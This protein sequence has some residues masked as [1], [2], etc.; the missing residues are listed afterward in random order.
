MN[1]SFYVDV[2]PMFTL[3][4][5][6]ILFVWLMILSSVST[7]TF[8]MDGNQGR[9]P[10]EYLKMPNGQLVPVYDYNPKP[11][12]TMLMVP[13][14]HGTTPPHNLPQIV[15]PQMMTRTTSTTF[16]PTMN[17][18]SFIQMTAPQQQ[19][20]PPV[21]TPPSLAPPSPPT[22][23]IPVGASAI[24]LAR[25]AAERQKRKNNDDDNPRSSKRVRNDERD[26][27]DDEDDE[28]DY[29]SNDYKGESSE[30]TEIAFAHDDTEEK[31][32]NFLFIESRNYPKMMALEDDDSAFSYGYE[33]HQRGEFASARAHFEKD[34]SDA[35]S[36]YMLAHYHEK[37]ISYRSKNLEVARRYYL[38]AAEHNCA[39]A[40]F[41]VGY[42]F[43]E[44]LCNFPKKLNKAIHWYERAA[45]H[46]A[47][48]RSKAL[49][50]LGSIYENEDSVKDLQRALKIY[51]QAANG[52]SKGAMYRL[53]LFYLEND[54]EKAHEWLEK[55][56]KHGSP[57]AANDLGIYYSGQNKHKEA[58]KLYLDSAERNCR[59]GHYNVALCYR[60]GKGTK[61]N[62]TKAIKHFQRA[63]DLGDDDAKKKLIK[64]NAFNET[65]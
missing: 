15:P 2:P 30:E 45:A 50:N 42:Y 36:L 33:N 37:A 13:Y 43:H 35:R 62:R 48:P 55:A 1:K 32:Q 39:E 41:L 64:L 60:D 12:S 65:K 11:V 31:D 8:A 54:P 63:Y 52:K 51:L 14:L 24:S 4:S 40:Q 34:M 38:L 10:I 53:Y 26:S 25:E 57:E 6:R 29:D 28:K 47:N 49:I 19:N 56:H 58:F 23:I 59:D 27:A 18:P 16:L 3:V 61:K 46:Q 21:K 44:G 17:N 9:V 5:L 22:V 20:T 7:M